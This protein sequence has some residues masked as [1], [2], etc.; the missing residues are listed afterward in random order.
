[1]QNTQN[2]PIWNPTR[3]AALSFLFTPTFGSY[4]Q[5]SNWRTLGQPERAAASKVWFYVSLLVLAAMAAVTVGFVGKS[6]DGNDAIRGI[7]NVGGLIYFFIWYLASG[8]KQASYVNETFGKTYAKKSMAKPI[9]AGL[10]C[11]IAYSVAVFGLLAAIHSNDGDDDHAADQAS[12]GGSSFSLANLLGGAHGL[13]CANPDVKE[14]V[15]EGYGKQ[16]VESGIPDLVWAVRDKRIKVHLDAIHETARNNDSKNI[17]CAA[18]FV[19]DFPKDDL[20]RATQ[21]GEVFQAL[22]MAHRFSPITDPT[23]TTP[24]SYQVATASDAEER[25]QGPIVTLT[26]QADKATDRQLQTYATYY[27]VLAY[28]TPDITAASANS[29][30]WEK[31]Y[32]AA[33]IQACSKTG[34]VDRCTCQLNAFEKVVSEQDMGRISFAMQTSMVFGGRYANFKKLAAALDQQ[35][36]MTQS[37]AAVLGDQA[38]VTTVPAASVQETAAVPSSDATQPEAVQPAQTAIVASFD[39][40]KAASK[41]ER[42]ICSS[43]ETASADK[44]LASV[45]RAAAAKSSDPAALKQQQREWLKDRNAC[46]DAAC[47]LKTT[48]ARIQALSAM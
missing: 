28:A 23:F 43:P 6:A 21:Q 10:A 4:L 41:I 35:C 14:S 33:A 11:A 12:A 22:M 19:I 1:M 5:A 44:Q 36:P 29:K 37:L 32:K 25:K 40:T 7:V 46:D 8:R 3:V 2:Q 42:L 13:D 27:T 34:G 45:Y 16:L 47:L 18:N 38:A 24:V 30:P 48:E 9:M 31:E 26:T 15:I 17:D 20:E 39:C